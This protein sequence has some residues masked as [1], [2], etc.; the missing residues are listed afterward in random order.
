[1]LFCTCA[2][3]SFYSSHVN[4]HL[5]QSNYNSEHFSFFVCFVCVCFIWQSTKLLFNYFVFFL[6]I[7]I[8]F[9]QMPIQNNENKTQFVGQ[10]F[11]LRTVAEILHWYTRPF[12]PMRSFSFEISNIIIYPQIN[13]YVRMFEH[14]L[15]FIFHHSSAMRSF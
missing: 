15:I 12:K 1:M 14:W 5:T 4:Q 7:T 8:S 10:R 11:L 13:S 3:I 9:R 6:F 2:Q